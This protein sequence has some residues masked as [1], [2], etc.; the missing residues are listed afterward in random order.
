MRKHM[1]FI[2]NPFAGKGLIR[3]KLS[4][5]VE[6]FVQGD[7]QVT[8]HATRGKQDATN[9]VSEIGSDFDLIVCAGGDGTL[10][11]VTLGIMKCKKK[12]PCGYIP[13]GTTNDVANSLGLQRNPIKAAKTAIEGTIFPYDLGTLNEDYFI[14]VA[15][16]GA[17][18]DVSYATSQSTKNIFG[19]LAYFLEGVKRI[20]SLK[21]YRYKVEYEE[22]VI[23]DDFIFGM[24]SNS[25]SVAGFKGLNSASVSLNDGLFEVTLIKMPHNPVDLQMIINALLLGDTSS[26]HIYSFH[27]NRLTLKSDE[28]VPWT[29]DGE[30]GGNLKE[31]E[32]VNHKSAV[33]YM[34]NSKEEEIE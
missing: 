34:V 18:T 7:Y 2:Y 19:R 24:I 20:P 28:L 14:Y 21:S 23:E 17:F 13:A 10:N 16:F 22:Q 29:L 11:E 5:I 15:G 26:K 33:Q 4:N 6:I 31:A 1:L 12:P 27:T 8:I 9:I 25:N 32:V 3:N 30:F